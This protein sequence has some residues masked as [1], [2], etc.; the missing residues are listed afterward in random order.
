VRFAQSRREFE[1][2][3]QRVL[4]NSKPLPV[5]AS[6]PALNQFFKLD[7]KKLI[8][9]LMNDAGGLQRGGVVPEFYGVFDHND[10]TKRMM[11]AANYGAVI[12]ISWQWQDRGTRAVNR[13][14]E[15]YKLGVNYLMYGF[16]H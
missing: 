9:E 11:V 5:D 13:G 4:P 6:N 16:T 3:I 8:S 14:N 12:H 15:A 1:K 2:Q 7:P 10:P